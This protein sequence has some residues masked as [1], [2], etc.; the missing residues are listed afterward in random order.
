MIRHSFIHLPGIGETTERKLWDQGVRSWDDLESSLED[1]FRG[2]RAATLAAA[3]EESRVAL[4]SREFR[5]FCDRMKSAHTWRMVSECCDAVAYLDIETTGLG[6]PPAS[7]S[8]TI[9]VSFKGEILIEHEHE[10]KRALLE[11]L[12]DEASLVVTF[13]GASFDLP[14]LRAEFDMDFNMPHVDLR[15]WMRRLGYTGGLKAIQLALPEIHQRSSMDI[16]GF[17]AVRLWRMY[18]RGV[19]RALET[20]MTY[21]AEDSICLE[22]MLYLAHE[23]EVLSHPH[24]PLQPLPEMRALPKIPTS[25]CEFVYGLLRGQESWNIPEDW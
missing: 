11:R 14:F 24:L 21:N 6:F 8:T 13:N 5:Y 4:E 12:N 1:M 18:K 2:K 3:I 15:M 19:P 17:D 16:D 10:K 23:R 9:A 25:V 20:L 7:H 22:P